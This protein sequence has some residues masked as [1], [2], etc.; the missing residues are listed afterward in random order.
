MAPP[1]ENLAGQV[2]SKLRVLPSY[3]YKEQGGKRRIQWLVFCD[4]ALGGCG[5]ECWM[6][7]D[8]LL[9][10]RTKTKNCKLCINV[11]HGMS[12]TPEY[13]AWVNMMQRCYNPKHDKY[14]EYGGRGIEV[15][16]RWHKFENFY[17][18]M[19]PRPTEEHSLDKMNNYSDYGPNNAVWATKYEQN[20]NRRSN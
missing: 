8:S 20:F 15:E 5:N 6:S 7:R 2:F 13:V 3:R 4:P 12:G 19:G 14:K 16:A 10:K 1:K 11:T 18:D 17:A 9:N